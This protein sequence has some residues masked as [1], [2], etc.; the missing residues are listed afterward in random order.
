MVRESNTVSLYLNGSRVYTTTFTGSVSTSTSAVTVGAN[1]SGADPFTGYMDD[2][3][4]TKGLARYTGTTY[5]IPSAP[6][7]VQ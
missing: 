7:P 5:T 6:F 3:R 2:I 1:A 4:I